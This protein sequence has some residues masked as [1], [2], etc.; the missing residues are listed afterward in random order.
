MAQELQQEG[1][2]AQA[3]A[4][5]V[6]DFAALIQKEFKPNNEARKSRI[7]QAVQ[8]LAQQALADAQIIGDDVFTTLDAMKAA[9]DRKLSEQVNRS[10]HSRQKHLLLQYLLQSHQS[11]LPP[12]RKR[13]YDFRRQKGILRRLSLCI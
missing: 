1:G 8:T 5:A 12:T 4:F 9:I 13:V 7:E 11:L 3:E 6:D 10:L 2:A